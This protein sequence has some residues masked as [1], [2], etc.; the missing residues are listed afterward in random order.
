MH[1]YIVSEFVKE[2]V[3]RRGPAVSIEVVDA[4]CGHVIPRGSFG[5]ELPVRC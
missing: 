1:K 2:R 5:R 4:A 3:L